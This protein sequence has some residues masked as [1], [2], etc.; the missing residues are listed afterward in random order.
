MHFLDTRWRQQPQIFKI[1][2]SAQT[3]GVIL[4]M[5]L[6]TNIPYNIQYM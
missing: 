4:H 1:E 3:A 6:N 5:V 2:A